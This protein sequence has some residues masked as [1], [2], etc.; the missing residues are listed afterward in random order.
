[1]T[2]Q[3]TPNAVDAAGNNVDNHNDGETNDDQNSASQ[4]PTGDGDG[5]QNDQTELKK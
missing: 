2:N 3:D 5:E 4:G 1:M